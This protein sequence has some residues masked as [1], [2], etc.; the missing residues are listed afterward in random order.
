MFLPD[1][2]EGVSVRVLHK[3]FVKI[4]HLFIPHWISKIILK[5]LQVLFLPCR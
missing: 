1:S 5:P 2:F 3:P 4:R